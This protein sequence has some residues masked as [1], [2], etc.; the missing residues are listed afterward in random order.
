MD[1]GCVVNASTVAL[2][3][4][5]WFHGPLTRLEAERRLLVA[6]LQGPG[7]PPFPAPFFPPLPG[8]LY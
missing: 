4:A 5:A 1:R 7:R 8:A 6:S 2:G 3:Q